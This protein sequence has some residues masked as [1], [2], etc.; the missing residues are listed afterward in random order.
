[1][2]LRSSCPPGSWVTD[3][4]ATYLVSEDGEG[5]YSVGGLST[6]VRQIYDCEHDL[7]WSQFRRQ[8]KRFKIDELWTFPL[9]TRRCDSSASSI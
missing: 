3:V 8:L 9:W 2:K 1:E 5:V 4:E 6:T 7:E